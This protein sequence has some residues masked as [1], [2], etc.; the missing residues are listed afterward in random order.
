MAE[1]RN[2]PKS[3]G[4][5]L[6]LSAEKLREQ[7]LLLAKLF[8][9]LAQRNNP[10]VRY[11]EKFDD[12]SFKSYYR[13]HKDAIDRLYSI[14]AKYRI[15]APTFLRFTLKHTRIYTP[16]LMLRPGL[17]LEYAKRKEERNRLEKIYSYFQKS[18]DNVAKT[19][20]ERDITAKE[21]V[22]EL[23][24]KNR[25]AYEFISGRMSKYFIASIQNFKKIYELLDEMNKSELRII[26]NA[27][28][29]LNAMLQ[30][31]CLMKTGS[32]ARPMASVESRIKQLQTE[33]SKTGE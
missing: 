30:D 4:N 20:V 17:F 13:T 31:A 3:S 8:K 15:D 29:E 10:Y 12:I 33:S 27:A 18:V 32:T 2:S 14:L 11:R 6:N 26:Y 16:E 28:D 19:C 25:L 24:V 21:F 5:P 23:I 1:S 22:K 7:R 9:Y